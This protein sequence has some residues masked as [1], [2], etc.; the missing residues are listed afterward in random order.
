ML[1]LT[2]A[3]M[4]VAVTLAGKMTL[5]IWH[6][7]CERRGIAGALAG[8][9]GAYMKLLDPPNLAENL[10]DIS[11]LDYATR[12]NRLRSFP[13]TPT[14]HPAFDRLAD[15][16]GLLPAAEAEDVS[17]IYNVVSGMR[18]LVSNFSDPQFVTV[19]DKMQIEY[20][21]TLAN[22][23]EQEC[24]SMGDL[25]DRLKKISRQSFWQFIR[26]PDGFWPLARRQS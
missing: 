20:F 16:I 21:T 1:S 10:R 26:S 5:D 17:A 8:E 4:T 18:V 13:K 9:I 15:R 25:T 24:K 7:H 6:R 14:G 19:D 3:F 12:K 2:I 22:R 11:K 23:I